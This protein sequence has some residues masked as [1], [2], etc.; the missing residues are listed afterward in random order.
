MCV[1]VYCP[2]VFSHYSGMDTDASTTAQPEQPRR[3]GFTIFLIVLA[4]V[5]V[6][7]ALTFWIVRTYIFPP[8]SS[9][10]NCPNRKSRC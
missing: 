3:S 9:R 7:A 10:S 4:T 1:M 8:N 2:A 5:V 6:T